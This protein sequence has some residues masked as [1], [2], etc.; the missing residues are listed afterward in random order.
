MMLLI[1]IKR[2]LVFKK[3][4]Y[5]EIAFNYHFDSASNFSI[6]IKK[7]TGKTPS[8]LQESLRQL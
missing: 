3:Q 7:H 6:F 2:D 4:N 8:Q 5:K 1:A